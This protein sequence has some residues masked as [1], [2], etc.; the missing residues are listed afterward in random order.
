M[1]P[2]AD[3]RVLDASRV[4][5]GPFCGQILGDLGAEVIKIERPGSGDETRGWGPPV[6][7][8]TKRLFPLLQ[9]QQEAS[10]SISTAEGLSFSMTLPNGATCSGKFPGRQRRQARRLP[11]EI[12][13]AKSSADRLLDLRV[14]PNRTVDDMPGYDFAVQG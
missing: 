14:R 7:R 12:A 3:V 1:T 13:R 6:R 5:A 2:L 9:P 11:G 4:L 8:R 10:P